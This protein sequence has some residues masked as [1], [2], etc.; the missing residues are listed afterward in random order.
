MSLEDDGRLVIR[1][2]RVATGKPDVIWASPNGPPGPP[3]PPLAAP[4][5]LQEGEYLH[6][7]GHHSLSAGDYT[8]RLQTD[9]DLVR[10]S[11]VHC[12]A[13]LLAHTQRVHIALQAKNALPKFPLP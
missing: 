3:Q 13:G 12:A 7:Y 4:D 10:W 9:W 8:F 11:H 6:P 5:R 2:V 1:G